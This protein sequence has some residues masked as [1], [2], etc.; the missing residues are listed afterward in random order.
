MTSTPKTWIAF[1]EMVDLESGNG[2]AG[3]CDVD[4]C[5]QS[6]ST[7]PRFRKPLDADGG[8]FCCTVRGDTSAFELE[9]GEMAFDVVGVLAAL[10]FD[11]HV[12]CRVNDTISCG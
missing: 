12:P 9:V 1:P 6:P 2:C 4:G 3:D 8:K 11:S 7:E 10:S 5:E